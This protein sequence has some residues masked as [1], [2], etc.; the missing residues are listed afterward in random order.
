MDALLS[1]S[2]ASAV[3]G[4]T[5]VLDGDVT[6]QQRAVLP[7]M[8]AGKFQPYQQ[9]PLPALD[10]A[11]SATV[12]SPQGLLAVAAARNYTLRFTPTVPAVWVTDAATPSVAAADYTNP[13]LATRP[14]AFTL[15]LKAH[16]PLGPVLVRPTIAEELKYGWVQYATLLSITAAAAWYIRSVLFGRLVVET[17]V[18]ADAPRSLTKL[19]AA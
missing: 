9:S 17:V 18:L 8:S 14:R 7:P 5:L 13:A 3:P 6:L 12:A 15:Q 2:H 4:Q 11:L 16:V 10:S 19:H 1:V